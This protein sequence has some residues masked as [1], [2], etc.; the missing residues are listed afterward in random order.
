LT[1]RSFCVGSWSGGVFSGF[2]AI[3]NETLETTIDA[4]SANLQINLLSDIMVKLLNHLLNRNRFFE[5]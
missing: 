4:A 1:F 5:N 3:P 2:W